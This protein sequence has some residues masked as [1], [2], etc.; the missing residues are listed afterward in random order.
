MSFREK[1]ESLYQEFRITDKELKTIRLKEEF[2]RVKVQSLKELMIDNKTIL[3]EL[4][5]G[6]NPVSV[7]RMNKQIERIEKILE[8]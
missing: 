4:Q 7:A 1:C 5:S 6:M 3:K 2:L 8:D